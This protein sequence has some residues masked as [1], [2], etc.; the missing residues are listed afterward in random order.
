MI[1]RPRQQTG[2]LSQYLA[3]LGAEPVF[4]PVIEIAP[5]EDPGRIDQTLQELSRFDWIVF[6]SAK[7]VESVWQRLSAL[8][9]DSGIFQNARLAAI[10]PATA[11]A[12]KERGLPVDFMPEK[13]VA[14]A[15]AAG[16][17]QVEG[18]HFLLFNAEIARETL[19]GD[20][21]ER[22]AK[23]TRVPVYR[24]LAAQPDPEILAELER[25]VDI[26]TLTSA[27]AAQGFAQAASGQP[28]AWMEQAVIACIGP[29]TAQAARENGLAVQ[30][31]ADESTFGGLAEALARYFKENG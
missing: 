12:M 3:A 1:T 5:M 11:E 13:Y 2:K 19:A 26:I 28:W 27:S 30:V 15:I 29:V 9:L 6:T 16:I 25:G 31:V 10:G 8:K 7:G 17:R 21:Q 24:T 23:V 14:E 4:F 20:L 22:G 18:L